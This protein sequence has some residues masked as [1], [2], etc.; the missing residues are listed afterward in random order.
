MSRVLRRRGIP[1][2]VL[3][4]VLGLCACDDELAGLSGSG[5]NDT[6]H[7]AAQAFRYTVAAAEAGTTFSLEGVTGSVG[8]EGVAALDTV[9]IAGQRRV[10]SE[11]TADA[12]AHLSDLQV[13]VAHSGSRVDV[14]TV[15]PS[16]THGRQYIVDYEIRVPSAWEVSATNVTGNIEVGSCAN[17]LV[18]RCTTGRVSVDQCAGNVD[19]DLVTGDIGLKGIRGNLDIAGVTGN[20]SAEVDL[21][22]AGSCDIG[23]VTGNLALAVPQ[24]TSAVFSAS[25]VTGLISLTHL[26]L[27]DASIGSRLITG[28]LGSGSGRIRLNVTTGMVSVDGF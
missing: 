9:V 1:A 14:R 5:S 13:Q 15:Q 11:S 2:L 10:R 26:A 24:T 16:D 18:L 20:V 21:P 27:D 3:L 8:I 17:D 23:L 7:E 4:L 12:E 19:V 28:T 22:D 25:V 6:D